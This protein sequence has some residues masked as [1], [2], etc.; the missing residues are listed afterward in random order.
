MLILL[1]RHSNTAVLVR[2]LNW[3]H[4]SVRGQRE[5]CQQDAGSR[6][7]RCVHLIGVLGRADISLDHDIIG[8]TSPRELE[9]LRSGR[10]LLVH[11]GVMQ[12]G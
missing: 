1:G 3:V 4:A 10:Q 5:G 8:T 2:D 12:L 11:H 9:D 6:Q 7:F